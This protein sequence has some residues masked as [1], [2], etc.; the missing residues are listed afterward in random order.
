MF[1]NI[2]IKDKKENILLS[3]IEVN[4]VVSFG[5]KATPSSDAIKQELSKALEVEKDLIVIK[6]INNSFGETFV[7]VVAFQYLS[8]DELKNIEPRDKKAEKAKVEAEKK[9]KEGGEKAEAPAEEK[10]EE[11]K[12]EEKE[13]KKTEEKKE[14]PKK[15]EAPA[16]K[17][18]EKPAEEKKEEPKAEEKKEEKKE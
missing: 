2:E 12:A 1:L 7:E 15:E 9:A 13:E 16:E 4:A 6:K 8:K 11:P 5:K 14:E 17:K 18:E 3:R 10:K